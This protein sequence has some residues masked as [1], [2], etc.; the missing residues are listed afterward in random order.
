M[1]APDETNDVIRRSVDGV[2]AW[3]IQR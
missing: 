2:L 1:H 3:V